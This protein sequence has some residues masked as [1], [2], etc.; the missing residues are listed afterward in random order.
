MSIRYSNIQGLAKFT[1]LH[2][3]LRSLREARGLPLRLPAAAAEIDSALLSK[4]ELGQ[5]LPTR[6]QL[7]ALTRFYGI[8]NGPFEARR[9]AEEMLR[10]HGDDPAL[11]E[12]TAIIREEAGEYRV[13][14]IR[15]SVNKPGK[16]VSNRKKTKRAAL[17]PRPA[18]RKHRE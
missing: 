4:I 13:K 12:A 14:N 16:S 8:E 10:S 15:A 5:R 3:Q 7:A 2:V 1:S 6:A 18:R 11:A 17:S 9:L